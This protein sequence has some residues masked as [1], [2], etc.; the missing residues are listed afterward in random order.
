MLATVSDSVNSAEPNLDIRWGSAKLTS[1]MMTREARADN[2][3]SQIELFRSSHEDKFQR[4][5][6]SETI[7]SYLLRSK[8]SSLLK[9]WKQFREEHLH[10]QLCA[11]AWIRGATRAQTFFRVV[12]VSLVPT[13]LEW[14]SELSMKSYARAVL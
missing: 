7:A 1:W 5:P 4:T 13:N 2:A 9:K 6:E 11:I 14:L 8:Q 10:L 12:H 3:L